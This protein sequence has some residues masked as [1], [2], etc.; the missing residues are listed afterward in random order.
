MLV[1]IVNQ[2]GKKPSVKGGTDHF[3]KIARGPVPEPSLPGST[4]HTRTS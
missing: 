3:Q 1:A 4:L 2:N